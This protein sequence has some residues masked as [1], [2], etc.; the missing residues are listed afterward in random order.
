[1]YPYHHSDYSG[2][3]SA[4]LRSG[5]FNPSA[6][7]PIIRN[8][9]KTPQ[10]RYAKNHHI[11]IMIFHAIKFA[12]DAHAGQYRKGT[13][14]PYISHPVN[15]MKT[16]CEQGCDDETITAGI[17]HDTVEDTSVTLEMVE[18][19]FGKRVARL[20]AGA[21]EQDK[22]TDKHLPEPEWKVRKQNTLNHLEQE[23]DLALLMISCADKLDNARAILHDYREKG[24]ELW[25]RFKAG[26][27]EQ[28]WY[29][30]SLA[31]VLVK[32]GNKHGNPLLKLAL[33]LENTVKEIFKP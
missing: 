7:I 27:D 10:T 32:Q 24:E 4:T 22:I 30:S 31:R 33:E 8:I 1:M 6:H 17:L 25:S 19:H 16:L 23:T 18:Q 15:V 3:F 21:S 20:V 2:P 28:K 5:K 29:Y 14:I 13:C 26:K 9:R 11:C 12:A